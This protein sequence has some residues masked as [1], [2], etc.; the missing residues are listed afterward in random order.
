MRNAGVKG[1]EF[2]NADGAHAETCERDEL[3]GNEPRRTQCA[4]RL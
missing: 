2:V 4:P 1:L 3:T